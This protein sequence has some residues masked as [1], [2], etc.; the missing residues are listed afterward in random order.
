MKNILIA[1]GGTGGH[2]YPG[3]AIAACLKKHVPEATITFVGSYVGMEKDIVPRYGYPMEFIR[4]RGFEKG[5]SLKTIAALK[6]VLF[7]SVRDSKKLLKKYHPAIVIG[8]GGFTSGMLLKEAAH[9]GIPTL[10]HEQNAFPGRANRMASRH[11][12]CVALSF[13]EAKQYFDGAHTVLCGNPVRDEF[14]SVSKQAMR[15][16]LGLKPEQKMVLAMGGSQGAVSINEAMKDLMSYYYKN[17]KIIIYQLTGKKNYETIEKELAKKHIIVSKD[18]NCRLLGS[19]NPMEVLMGAS[20]LVIGRSGASSIAEMAASGTPAILIPYP[21][22]AGDHQR[23]NAQAVANAGAGI[24]IEDD[25]LT[26]EM[27]IDKVS[28]LIQDDQKLETMHECAKG[29]AKLDADERI[30]EE[31]M[32]LMHA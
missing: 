1:A 15:Q 26:G 6:N 31:I 27:L 32:K 23:F 2:I 17:K 8:T 7:D 20:D 10:I 13:I 28:H 25:A 5:F 22:A 24:V 29:Y 16:R 3:L 11:A 4:A 14:K 18:S 19:S 21:Y 9:E 30:V 12:D